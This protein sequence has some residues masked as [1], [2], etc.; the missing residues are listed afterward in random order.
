MEATAKQLGGNVKKTMRAATIAAFLILAMPAFA[1]Q[2]LPNL[3]YNATL[4]AAC[5][6]PNAF[7]ANSASPTGTGVSGLSGTALDVNSANYSLATVTVSGTYAGVTVNFDFSDPTSG[8][9]Y[10]QELCARTDVNVLELSEVLPSNQTRAWQCPLFATTRFRVRLSA[11]TSG[12]VNTWITV[13]QSSI[14]PSPTVANLPQPSTQAASAFTPSSQAALTTSVNIKASAGNVYG[15]AANGGAAGCWIQFINSAGAGTLGTGVVFQIPL[16]G[17]ATTVGPGD[18]ALA[19][20]TTGIAVGVA[21]A[22]NG[23]SAC[24]TSGQ[25]TIFFQ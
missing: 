14:D 16:V 24:A 7:C 23:A 5:A 20:F 6:T 19:N 4:N 2:A 11:Y 3:T 10:F 22:F 25:V 1:Q 18:I 8:T 17:T 15:V 13:T 21:S 9:T 12:A